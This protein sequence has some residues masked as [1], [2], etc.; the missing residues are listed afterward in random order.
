MKLNTL[1]SQILHAKA[2]NNDA[3]IHKQRN[4][5][6]V[7]IDECKKE[8]NY[9]H[10]TNRPAQAISFGGS[11]V[12]MS[13]KLIKNKFLNK[14]VGFVYD[15]E[16]AYNA[17]FS[18]FIA[19][20]L[21]PF[22]VLNMPGSEEKDKQLVATKNFL[23]AFLGSFFGITITGGIVKKSV[24]IINNNL[25]LVEIDKT[26]NKIKDVDINNE[27]LEEI[28]KK[29][30]QK[31]N[32]GLKARF[33]NAAEAFNGAQ[34]LNKFGNLVK[35]FLKAPTYTP[36][37]EEILE[38]KI[39][40]ANAFNGIHKQVFESN[41]NF[42]K[43]LLNDGNKKEAYN[44]FWKNI[45]GSPVAIGKAKISSLLLP[46]VVG[47]LFAKRAIDKS[48]NKQNEAKQDDKNVKFKQNPKNSN[49]SF[50]GSLQDTAI[51][52]IALNVEKLSMSKFGQAC[53]NSLA[54][55]PKILNKPS[56]R[57]ADLES[58]LVTLYWIN[59]TNKSKK[60]EPSQKLGLNVHSATVTIVSSTCAFIIDTLLDGLIDR[61]AKKYG[62]IIEEIAQTIPENIKQSAN[63]EELINFLK[64]KTSTLLNSE[65][66]V[67]SLSNVDLANKD[68]ITQAINSLSSTYKRQ[69]SKFKSL[70]IFT[71]V[72]RFLV[73]VLMVP[74]SG[75]LKKKIV[76]RQKQKEE[77]QN[78]T[79]RK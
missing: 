73:P 5:G 34:G 65:K 64:E 39:S 75:T 24:D 38:R 25:S 74:V 63:K 49:I 67:K 42:T 12:S 58:I 48:K 31:D 10:N 45:T 2:H 33:K 4:F 72:V 6:S 14:V 43:T 15:N 1:N 37:V 44:S 52:N 78:I 29:L 40:V 8:N 35:N 46:I 76:E 41:M 19:G 26:L 22:V 71:F 13:E 28:A 36:S 30:V 77:K 70:T 11:A 16:A 23:Q 9:K 69:L 50:K 7:T 54:S 27:K 47:F 66:I 20:M 56:A 3:Y 32:T 61:T 79:A 21:K 18:L 68:S 17:I 55:L 53:V 62:N 60:I 59:N 57:M 51:N